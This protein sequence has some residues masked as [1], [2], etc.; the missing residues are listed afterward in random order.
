MLAY[1]VIRKGSK[2]SDVFRLKAGEAVTIGRAPTNRIV[3]KDER[4][5]RYHAEIFLS[6]GQWTIR[7]LESRNGTL[8]NNDAVRGDHILSPGEVIL[9][10][11]CQIAFVHDLSNAFQDTGGKVDLSKDIGDDT[12][13]GEFVADTHSVALESYE[14]AN[15]T[16]RRGET[17]FLAAAD[18]GAANMPRLGKAATQLCR[19]AFELD[20]ATLR[21]ANRTV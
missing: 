19:L 13:A 9:I 7:D 8:V 21:Q 16:H 17:R 12:V 10:G 11:N 4:C 3:I 1:L 20:A 6:Q 15:I 14:P 5:S 18:A 2:W